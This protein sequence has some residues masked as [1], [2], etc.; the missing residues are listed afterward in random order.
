M[1]RELKAGD[2]LTFIPGVLIMAAMFVIVILGYVMMPI[3]EN[4]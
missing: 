3:L 2:V 1:D 4:F